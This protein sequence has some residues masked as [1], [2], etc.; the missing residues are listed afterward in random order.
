MS[1]SVRTYTLKS[2]KIKS[3]HTLVFLTDLHGTL[4]GP[5]NAELTALCRK[6]HPDLILCGGDM[7]TARFPHTVDVAREVFEELV[8]IAP[9]Y[10]GYGNHES[11]A[12]A[13]GSRVTPLFEA[14]RKD[15]SAMGVT[16]LVRNTVDIGD[17]LTLGGFEVSTKVYKKFTCPHLTEKDIAEGTCL[18]QKDS[19][20]T[21]LMAHNPRFTEDYFDIG[22]DL[23]LCGHFH[24][25]VMR[26]TDKQ[27][28]VSPYGF[29]FP[30]YGHGL[31][32][33]DDKTVIVSAGLGDH[34][35]P[36]RL[37]NP[38]ELIDIRLLPPE[39]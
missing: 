36:L 13:G 20:Y 21:L 33:K 15:V 5:H 35:I 17:D 37:N 1:L 3:P 19:R 2:H 24:G 32:K 18:R 9:V 4:H 14:Y 11:R 34:A 28:L 27:V 6:C 25:G 30:K 22:A 39:T 29:P 31:Y 23:T 7:L 16:W 8:T 12:A 26:F 38:M 10:A